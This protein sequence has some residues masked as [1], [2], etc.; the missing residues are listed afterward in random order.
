VAALEQADVEADG[1]TFDDG[2]NDTASAAQD[3]LLFVQKLHLALG[4]LAAEVEADIRRADHENDYIDLGLRACGV[5]ACSTV[6]LLV[7]A[8]TLDG[9]PA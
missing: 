8:C 3:D 6:E 2:S 1:A 5:G 9:W 7:C 4:R